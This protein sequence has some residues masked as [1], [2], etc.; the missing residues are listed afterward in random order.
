M[1]REPRLH[2]PVM[3]KP[4]AGASPRAESCQKHCRAICRTNDRFLS[5]QP[6]GRSPA[7]PHR[8]RFFGYR[9]TPGADSRGISRWPAS[10]PPA[11]PSAAPAQSRRRDRD[12]DDDYDDEF[13][14]IERHPS[15]RGRLSPEVSARAASSG[16]VCSLVSLAL[17]LVSFV[18]A[19]A[20]FSNQHRRFGGENEPLVVIVLLVVLGSFALALLAIVFSS[21]GLDQSN[22]YNRGHATAGLVCGIISLV[23]GS[24]VGLFSFCMGMFV[25]SIRGF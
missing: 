19:V 20:T 21:R 13:S 18:L 11:L 15:P 3:G 4:P 2:A 1:W 6:R 7:A 12:R 14:S 5:G 23:I 9:K 17:L 10:G 8:S 16:L 24:L 22:T 25:L